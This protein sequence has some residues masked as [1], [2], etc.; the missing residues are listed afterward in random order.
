MDSQKPSLLE[1]R[2]SV[3]KSQHRPFKQAA[4]I[5][6]ARYSLRKIIFGLER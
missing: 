4:N 2:V 1:M 3:S 5:C 6:S